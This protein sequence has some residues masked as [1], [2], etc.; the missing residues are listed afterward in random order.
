[1]KSKFRILAWASGLLSL[2]LFSCVGKFDTVYPAT[3]AIIIDEKSGDCVSADLIGQGQVYI[4]YGRKLVS[5]SLYEDTLSLK[6][7]AISNDGFNLKYKC[8]L[9]YKLQKSKIIKLYDEYGISYSEVFL[10]PELKLQIRNFSSKNKFEDLSIVP[11]S[12]LYSI[13]KEFLEQEYFILVDFEV[14]YFD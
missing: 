2:L 5:Y 9:I 4:P 13:V 8:T 7:N 14:E 10:E 6:G 11:S 3:V 12:I 1:M